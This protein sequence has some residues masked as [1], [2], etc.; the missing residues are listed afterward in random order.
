MKRFVV[1]HFLDYKI[2][3]SMAFTSK[4]QEI[5]VIL[6]E[7]HVEGMILSETFLVDVIIEKLPSGWNDFENYLNY[8]WKEMNFD[9]LIVRLRI[10]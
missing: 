6:H 8:M 1:G 2:V 5:Q 3:D 4:V 7:I 9:E 10:E